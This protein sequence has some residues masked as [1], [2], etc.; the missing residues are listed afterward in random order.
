MVRRYICLDLIMLVGYM[1][2]DLI[3][4]QLLQY[5]I[6]SYRLMNVDILYNPFVTAVYYV[7]FHLVLS[8]L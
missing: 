3:N 8:Q 4:I 5:C 6:L 1:Q 7:S 2:V